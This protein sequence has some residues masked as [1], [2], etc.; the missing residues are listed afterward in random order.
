MSFEK[1]KLRQGNYEFCSVAMEKEAFV[2]LHGGHFK[3]HES[4]HTRRINGQE[5]FD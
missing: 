1:R 4:S 5:R 2:P 3:G